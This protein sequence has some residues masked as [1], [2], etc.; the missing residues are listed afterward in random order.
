M[1]HRIRSSLFVSLSTAILCAV[2]SS[3]AEAQKKKRPVYTKTEGIEASYWVQGEYVGT[4]NDEKVGVQVLAKGDD[5][6]EAFAYPGGLPGDGWRQDDGREGPFVG[7]TE[8]KKTVFKGKDDASGVIE[9]QKL[10]V[11][12]GDGNELGTLKRVVR[13]SETLGKKPPEG[14]VVLFDGTN[15]DEWEGGKMIDKHLRCGT[16]SKKKFQS[17]L[18]HLEFRTPYQPKDRGQGRGNSGCYLQS[19]YEV[20]ILDSFTSELNWGHAGGIYSI[21]PPK[22]NMCYP[23]LQWQTY[24]IEFTAAKFDDNG[25]RVQD[26]TMTVWH[27]GVLVQDKTKIDKAKT[28]AAR[29]GESPNPGQLYLQDHSN[30]VVFRNI[31]VVPR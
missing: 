31:W 11:F 24:D 30:P 29:E 16:V 22:L 17:T 12:D 9:D 25:K 8:G 23:P 7:K 21:K 26:A 27:N 13:E 15:A 3:S 28:T 10:T 20:Q 14:A 1:N 5:N 4:V 6:F 19:R 2:L 18:V